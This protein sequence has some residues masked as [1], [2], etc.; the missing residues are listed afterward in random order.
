[1]H[2]LKIDEK[3]QVKKNNEKKNEKF[4]K[5]LQMDSIIAF[6]IARFKL[7]A[8]GK[9]VQSILNYKLMRPVGILRLPKE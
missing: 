7:T 1:M 2:P 5:S 9:L 8:S 6:K 3:L 4:E